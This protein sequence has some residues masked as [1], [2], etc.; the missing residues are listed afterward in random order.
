MDVQ[1]HK[2]IKEERAIAECLVTQDLPEWLA[3]P[4]CAAPLEKGDKQANLE[5]LGNQEIPE[6]LVHPVRLAS[7]VMLDHRGPPV[8]RV[9]QV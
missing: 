4:E 7:Q 9:H 2:A 5:N 1:D 3:K 8:N 6:L